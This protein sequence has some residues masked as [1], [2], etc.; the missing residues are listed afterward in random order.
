MKFFILDKNCMCY[1]TSRPYTKLCFVDPLLNMS[2][3]N[4]SC[5]YSRAVNNYYFL[6][7]RIIRVSFR[8]LF[9]TFIAGKEPNNHLRLTA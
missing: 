8:D 2:N 9:F 1:N 5:L 7:L 3:N 6:T 4:D